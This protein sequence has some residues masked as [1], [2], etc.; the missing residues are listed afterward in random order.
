MFLPLFP[1]QQREGLPWLMTSMII[2]PILVQIVVHLKVPTVL[3]MVVVSMPSLSLLKLL[4]IRFKSSLLP[5]RQKSKW[6]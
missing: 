2:S 1:Q 6:A 5:S 4:L 3:H